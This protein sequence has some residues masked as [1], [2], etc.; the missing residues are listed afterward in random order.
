MEVNVIGRFDAT[1][2]E[3]DNHGPGFFLTL[4]EIRW[5]NLRRSGPLTLSPRFQGFPQAYVRVYARK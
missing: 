2:L 1:P 3:A 5:L 4:L